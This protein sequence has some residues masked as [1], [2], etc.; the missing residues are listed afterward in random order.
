MISDDDLKVDVGVLKSQVSTLTTLC[1]KMDQ[2]IE[3]LVDQHDRHLVKVYE[4]IDQRRKETDMDIKELHERIDVVLDKVQISEKT[5]LEEIQ[6]LRADMQEHNTK[7]RQNI[8]QLLQWKWMIAGGVLVLSWLLSH[9]NF[10]IM[11][12]LLH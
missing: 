2:V 7:D 8:E 10:D 5:L 6:K 9:V 12:K 4:N 11:D 3:K 1:G